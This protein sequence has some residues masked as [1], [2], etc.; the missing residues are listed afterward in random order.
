MNLSKHEIKDSFTFYVHESK[1]SSLAGDL[2]LSLDPSV[3]DRIAHVFPDADPKVL[4]SVT[5][6][7][8]DFLISNLLRLLVSIY[9]RKELEVPLIALLL[10][11][12]AEIVD[13]DI[14]V[15]RPSSDVPDVKEPRSDDENKWDLMVDNLRVIVQ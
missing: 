15:A 9:G 7:F 4:E 5:G 10:S 11:K 1:D 6:K 3:A 14:D 8:T 2:V 12:T 13:E